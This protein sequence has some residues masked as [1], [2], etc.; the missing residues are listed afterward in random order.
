MARS[1]RERNLVQVAVGGRLIGAQ[2]VEVGRPLSGAVKTEHKRGPKF[3]APYD[4]YS[5]RQHP[6]LIPI[7]RLLNMRDLAST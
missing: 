7:R 6:R 1:I 5:L 2:V 4:G 3:R